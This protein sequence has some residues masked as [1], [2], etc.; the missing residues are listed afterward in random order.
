[1]QFALKQYQKDAVRDVLSTLEV[2]RE[3]YRSRGSIKSFALSSVTGSGKTV[4]AAS[5]I[6]A[7]IHGSTDFDFDGDPGAVVLWISKDPSLNEQTRSRII[8]SSDRISVGEL[9][10]LHNDYPDDQLRKGTVYFINPGKLASG[11]LL[12]TKTNRRSVTFW[13]ILDST[14]RDPSLTLYVILDEAHEGMRPPP[15]SEAEE[16]QSIALKII[17]GHNGYMP[18]PI[19]WGI[20]ATVERFLEAMRRAEGRG[21]EPN[22]VIDPLRVQESGLLKNS[23]VLD[24]PDEKGDFE[25]SLIRDATLDFVEVCKLWSEYGRRENL[26]EPVLPLLVVQIPNKEGS[27][28]GQQEE[29]TIVVRALDT[30]RR[31]YPDFSDDCVAHV[32]GDRGHVSLSSYEI[33]R[34]QPQDVQSST[35][36]RVLLAKDAVSTGWDCPRAEVLVSLRPARERVYITQM[37]G[38]MVR[39]PLARS[40]NDDRLNSASCYLPHFDRETAKAVAEEIMGIREQG[41]EPDRPTLKVLF[42]P[43][44]LVWNSTVPHDVEA[45]LSNLP[46]LSK[47]AAKP[48]PVK[49]LLETAVALAQ[50]ALVENPHAEALRQ[51][52]NVL[53]GQLAQHRDAVEDEAVSIREAE[54]RRFTAKR[55]TLTAVEEIER[56]EADAATVREAFGQAKRAFT[57]AVANGYLK[58]LYADVLAEDP[59]ADLTL[60][61]ARVAALARVLRDGQS[62]AVQPVEDA[63][64]TLTRH[65]LDQA[66]DAIALLNEERREV[67]EDLRGQ[68]RDPEILPI[69]IPVALRVEGATEEGGPLPRVQKHVLS[70]SRGDFPLDPRLNQW[71]R[72]VIARE[73]ARGSLVA[74]YRN[75]SAAG[76]HALRIPYRQGDVWKSLQPDFIFIDRDS[77]GRL[78]PAIVDP[79]SSHLADALG[80]LKGLAAYAE[81]YGKFY[82]RIDSLDLDKDGQ[83]RVL[84][85]NDRSVRRAVEGAHN[86]KDLFSSSVSR[87]Y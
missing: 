15:K 3:D 37:L 57:A 47:P 70:D 33:P 29:D 83:L 17:N 76:K 60:I 43:A 7:L 61:Q 62:I 30:I 75:P 53:D 56:H 54:I 16:R 48:R 6:E 52:F 63:A 85:M 23:L 69:E 1:V 36:V 59:D 77:D 5:V 45:F 42:S 51:L 46:S 82:S 66:R 31:H 38:R 24:I 28:R 14:I 35:R 2:C 40:T 13:E 19:V 44:D 68:G 50:D 41:P 10:I 20:S 39:T 4:I 81:T 58:R 55:G 8:E 73:T 22:I 79:H 49:R 11:N 71:E 32:L 78:I 64:E 21:T 18:A 80:R 74:W 67:Y 34:I 86:A 27:E 12:V 72:A 84:D 87:L 65:W 25:T 9:V 26:E